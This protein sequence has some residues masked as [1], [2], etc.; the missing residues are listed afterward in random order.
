MAAPTG[1]QSR[2]Y[3]V[4]RGDTFLSIARR[5]GLTVKQLQ[6]ANNISNPIESILDRPGHPV[7]GWDHKDSGGARNTKAR[8]AFVCFALL[9]LRQ[10][11]GAYAAFVIPASHASL[12]FF[13]EA[14]LLGPA[15]ERREIA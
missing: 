1:G 10:L 13:F 5:F 14:S 3:V 11:L 7:I 6:Q 2:S 8:S 15:Q 9:R 4:Q 12:G